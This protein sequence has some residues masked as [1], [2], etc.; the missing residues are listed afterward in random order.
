M[1]SGVGAAQ[2]IGLVVDFDTDVAAAVAV[3]LTQSKPPGS[4]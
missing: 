2:M 4:G 3:A 1:Y